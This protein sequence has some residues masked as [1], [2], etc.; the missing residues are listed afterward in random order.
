MGT[1]WHCW[2]VLC[3]REQ[4][5]CIPCVFCLYSV[6]CVLLFCCGRYAPEKTSE[7]LR[8]IVTSVQT[9]RHRQVTDTAFFLHNQPTNHATQLHSPQDGPQQRRQDQGTPGR[10]QS[11]L[12]YAS[13]QRPASRHSFAT[14]T[15][16]GISNPGVSNA[17]DDR[18]ILQQEPI[19]YISELSNGVCP[20]EPHFVELSTSKIK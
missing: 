16:S 9:S 3:C 17:A 4:L 7:A 19:S 8:D 2:C 18:T 20:N 15:Q 14:T 6:F 12:C 11:T 5:C 13:R 10:P 1:Y